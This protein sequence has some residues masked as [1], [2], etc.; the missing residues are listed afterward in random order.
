MAKLWPTRDRAVHLARLDRRPFLEQPRRK[1]ERFQPA[2]PPPA[3][4]A[5]V[6]VPPVPVAVA[7]VLADSWCFQFAALAWSTSRCRSIG[8]RRH[9]I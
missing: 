2:A 9:R 5:V 8:R 6:P 3:A 1:T 4:S 7:I